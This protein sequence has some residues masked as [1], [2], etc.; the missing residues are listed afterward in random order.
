MIDEAIRKVQLING[1]KLEASAVQHL[2][3][4]HVGKQMEVCVRHPL[5]QMLNTQ[6][7]G[8]QSARTQAKT[9]KKS[10]HV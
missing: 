7:L 8:V 10:H 5:A 2:R 3:K 6:A 9:K 4:E 1:V